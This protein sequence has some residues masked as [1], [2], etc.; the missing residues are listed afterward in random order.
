MRP[1]HKGPGLPPEE[2]GKSV[3]Q[4][5]QG[6]ARPKHQNRRR[7]EIEGSDI[8][9]FGKK[10]QVADKIP[11]VKAAQANERHGVAPFYRQF[12]PEDIGEVFVEFGKK[13][14]AA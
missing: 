3:Q 8:I 4:G 5:I 7:T 11:G 14:P 2:G 13:L 10:G 12:P 9:S 1:V 6:W